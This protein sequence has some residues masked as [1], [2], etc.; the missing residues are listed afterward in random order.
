MKQ[1]FQFSAISSY[2]DFEAQDLDLRDDDIG[3]TQK[4]SGYY[5]QSDIDNSTQAET[6]PVGQVFGG[7]DSRDTKD[8]ESVYLR[9]TKERIGKSFKYKLQYNFDPSLDV[10]S[11]APTEED[12]K[13]YEFDSFCVP[14]DSV[15]FDESA[16]DLSIIC[17]RT[18]ATPE[19]KTRSKSGK[20]KYKRIVQL[21]S[22]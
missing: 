6:Q 4:E 15:E 9:S 20:K 5:S 7:V 3:Y 13:D 8:M 17:E 16:D 18:A 2:F 11:Q 12:M 10:Y 14:N 19:R 21:F 22:P 1:L